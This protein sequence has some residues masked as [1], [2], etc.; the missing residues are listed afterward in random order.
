MGWVVVSVYVCLDMCIS[1]HLY[2]S[3]PISVYVC[4]CLVIRLAARLTVRTRPVSQSGRRYVH[5]DRNCFK[6]LSFARFVPLCWEPSVL[7]SG[8]GSNGR[9]G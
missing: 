4:L 2:P 3:L 8:L 9:Q 5:C 1:V 7:G 6:A